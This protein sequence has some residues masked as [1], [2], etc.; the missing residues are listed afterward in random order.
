GGGE[1]KTFRGHVVD[2]VQNDSGSAGED[3]FARV[4]IIK[5]L[6]RINGRG[7]IDFTEAFRH[8]AD[9]LFSHQAADGMELAVGVGDANVVEVNESDAADAGAGEAFR[10]P[11]SDSAHA[12]DH[13]VR[14]EQ[15]LHSF[16]TEQA[17]D[18]V[19]AA[20]EDI[21]GFLNFFV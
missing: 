7:R 14:A 11:T 19:E 20:V 10:G 4:L 12:D 8:H 17:P 18:A 3:G 6:D 21:I 5:A 9:F 2:C 1:K 15:T 13:D 16:V